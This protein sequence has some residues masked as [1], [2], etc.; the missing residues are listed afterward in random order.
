MFLQ[1]VAVQAVCDPDIAE[2][3]AAEEPAVA[4][5]KLDLVAFLQVGA[6]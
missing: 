2:E 6:F 3:N 4:A 1:L 5:A